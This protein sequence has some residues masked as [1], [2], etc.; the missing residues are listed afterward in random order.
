M[1]YA[2]II[3]ETM[4]RDDGYGGLYNQN[5][6]TFKEFKN[7]EELIEWIK[8]N[9]GYNIK[10]YKAIQYDDLAVKTTIKLDTKLF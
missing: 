4:Y 6:D 10:K 8:N 7:Q 9:T 1:K 5:M 3:Y 2:V